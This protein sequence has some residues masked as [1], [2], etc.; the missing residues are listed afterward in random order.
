MNISIKIFYKTCRKCQSNYE[1]NIEKDPKFMFTC[2]SEK[3][4][5]SH[6]KETGAG[7]IPSGV[8]RIE[9]SFSEQYER[10]TRKRKE[11][12][13]IKIDFSNLLSRLKEV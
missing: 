3:C 6:Y 13:A 1:F 7:F 2:C 10:I 12:D 9:L 8:E 4:F 5:I 11:L